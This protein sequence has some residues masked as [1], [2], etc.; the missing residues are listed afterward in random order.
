MLALMT[1]ARRGLVLI[2]RT[3]PFGDDVGPADLAERCA[4]YDRVTILATGAGADAEQTH[5]VPANAYPLRLATGA[6]R[7]DLIRT[8]GLGLLHLRP[9]S[10]KLLAHPRALAHAAAVE[11]GAQRRLQLLGPIQLGLD[12]VDTTTV[13]AVD[14]DLS[15]RLAELLRERLAKHGRAVE[16]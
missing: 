16:G 7:T 6:S 1:D 12:D 11:G 15:Q 13:E 2:T 10:G 9:A 4:D 14:D 8:T 3:F 5:D